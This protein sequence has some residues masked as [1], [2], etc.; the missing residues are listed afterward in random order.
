MKS[1][2]FIEG[3]LGVLW[4]KYCGREIEEQEIKPGTFKCE[5]CG[6]LLGY[7]QLIYPEGTIPVRDERPEN[8]SE[9]E[10]GGDQSVREASA[11][12]QSGTNPGLGRTERG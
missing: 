12:E 9:P 8:E 6:R 4:C 1:M 5:V 2:R 3:K 11:F 7:K 10:S